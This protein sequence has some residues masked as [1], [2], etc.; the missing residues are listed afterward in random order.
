MYRPKLETALR[1]Q[2][3]F[4]LSQGQFV[5]YACW[6]IPAAENQRCRA[7]AF[8]GAYVTQK[9]LILRWNAGM[10]SPLQAISAE[11]NSMISWQSVSTQLRLEEYQMSTC[12][13]CMTSLL[14]AAIG[15]VR[16]FV[17]VLNRF[18]RYL[19]LDQDVANCFRCFW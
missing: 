17:K 8:F 12:G 15:S 6:G 10:N 3:G 1:K 9:A 4:P 2:Q 14:N 16:R 13:S 19:F 5:T 11:S 7:N 18:Y